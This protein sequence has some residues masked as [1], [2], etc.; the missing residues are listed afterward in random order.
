MTLKT[1]KYVLNNANKKNFAVAGL[2]TLGWEDA[3]GFVEASEATGIPIVLQAGPNC[4]KYTPIP[5]IGK[6]FR[7]LAEQT[8][9]H[10]VCHIDHAYTIRECLE[11]IDN[12]FTSVMFDGSRFSIKKNINLVS[13]VVKKAQAAKVSVEGE[14][15]F[16]GYDKG[17]ISEGTKIEDAKFFANE[18]GAD[19]MAISVGNTHL[20]QK[21]RSNIDFEKI[22]LIERVTNIPL[23][24]H[25]A[26]GISDKIRKKI[27]KN[28]N[29]AKFNIGTEIRTHFGKTVRKNLLK[30]KKI[31]D[32]IDILKPS[33]EEIKKLTINIINN[34][35]PKK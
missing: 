4:R 2:V 23:V 19:A 15:G 32:R 21:K 1:L 8:K 3:L 30:N 25:G 26:S 33:I 18:S 7:Y 11:G 27:A 28:T 34:I 22:K 14:V 9:S 31:Y 12:G 6:M 17:R 13:S 10:I 29:V 24:I 16:V 20:Q 5:V 35:G